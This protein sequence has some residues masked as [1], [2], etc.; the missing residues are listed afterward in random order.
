MIEHYPVQEYHQHNTIGYM[1]YWPLLRW[2]VRY[3]TYRLVKSSPRNEHTD[4]VCQTLY[5]VYIVY[6]CIYCIYICMC[7]CVI[8]ITNAPTEPISRYVHEQG[9]TRLPINKLR[10]TDRC[11]V[12]VRAWHEMCTHLQGHL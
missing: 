3:H 8:F 9:C 5:V 11:D 6:T 4:R 12:I 2:V 10:W 7:M 1:D